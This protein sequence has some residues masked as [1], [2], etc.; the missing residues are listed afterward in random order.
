MFEKL[1]REDL[2]YFSAYSSARSLKLSGHTWL[3]ANELAYDLSGKTFN[4]YPEPQPQALIGALAS[5]YHVSEDEILVTRGS[6]EG[7]D[8][9]MRL[10]CAYQQDAVMA[11][12]PT[13]GMYQIC[14]RLQGVDYLEY[15]LKADNSFNIDINELLQ[16]LHKSRNVKILFVCSPNNPT[17]NSVPL[18]DIAKLCQILKDKTMVVIDEAYIEF[19]NEESAGGLIG[20]YDNL[21][22]LRTLSKAHGL[23]GERVGSVVSNSQ[24]IQY[25][26]KIIAPYPI[27][28][29]V[30]ANVLSILQTKDQRQ[31]DAMIH[32]IMDHREVLYGY[33]SRSTLVKSVYP[34]AGNFLL[35]C[36]KRDIFDALI[37]EGIVVRSMAKALNDP[38]MLRITI[39]SA[40]EMQSLVEVLK[41][42]TNEV[43]DA[44]AE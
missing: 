16:L 34:S 30:A 2:R 37:R 28:T 13:F 20:E 22:I 5:L 41:K 27:A 42:I 6:D 7:I 24:L 38:R 15:E 25:L 36:F 33:L 12:K 29:S 39:G 31:T 26:K 35:V 19:S 17:G 40:K 8:L 9:L 44:A 18:S 32:E 21:V 14:A 23:A 10:F 3:N 11:F 1:I 4:R 43:V